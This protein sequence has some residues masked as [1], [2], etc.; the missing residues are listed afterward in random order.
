MPGKRKGDQAMGTISFTWWN[1]QNFFDTDDDPISKDFRYTKENGWTEEVFNAK[2]DNLAK[3][4]RAIH[5]GAG[6]E[7][8]AVA[9]IEKDSLLEELIEHMGNP[10][11]R[12]VRDPNGTSDLRGIDVAVA[13]DTRKLTV[14]SK[15]SH[16]IHLRYRT[17]D[18]F[19]VVFEVKESGETFV[20]IS[21]HWPSR[22]FIKNIGVNPCVSLSPSILPIWLSPTLRLSQWNTR[23]CGLKRI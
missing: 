1:L 10:H 2:K 20:V 11:L 17:R 7:L 23:N 12:V 8:L 9:E 21:S 6:P 19:E 18:V 16:L 5:N 14:K 13:Y 15:V 4:L 22:E 3:V